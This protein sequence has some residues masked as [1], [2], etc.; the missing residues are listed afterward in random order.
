MNKIFKFD[1]KIREKNFAAIGGLKDDHEQK[2]KNDPDNTSF[3]ENHV[4]VTVGV[5]VSVGVCVSVSGGVRVHVLVHV[6]MSVCPYLYPY[7]F[8]C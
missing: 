7:L 1:E 5:S 2:F 6:S 4:S 3:K 8:P